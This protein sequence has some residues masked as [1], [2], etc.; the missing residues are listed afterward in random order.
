MP[1]AKLA[2]PNRLLE[3]EPSKYLSFKRTEDKNGKIS[4]LSPQFTLRSTQTDN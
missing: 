2:S 4:K 3:I 1:A